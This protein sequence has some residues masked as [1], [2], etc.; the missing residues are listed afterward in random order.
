MKNPII[1]ALF[2]TWFTG[3]LFCLA[4]L[5][6]TFYGTLWLYRFMLA[7][8]KLLLI[9]ALIAVA[10][11]AAAGYVFGPFHVRGRQVEFT[12]EKGATLRAIARTLRQ[13]RVVPSSKAL[14]LWVKLAGIEKKIQA[15]RLSFFAGEG[16]A[17]A[18]Q[19]LLHAEP[20]EVSVT[21]P[22]GLTIAQTAGIIAHVLKADSAAFVNLCLDSGFAKECG[23]S[24]RSLEGY[25]FPDSYRFPPDA[26]PQDIVKKLAGH[27]NEMYASIVQTGTAT[28]LSRRETVVLA[29]I[30]EKEAAIA[31]ERPLISGVF[32]NRLKKRI[33]LG[34]DPTTRYVLGKFSGPLLASDLALQSPYNTR[35]HT[36]L[37]PG[38]ICSPG[39]ASLTAALCPQ[40]TT[41]LYFVARWDGSGSHDFSMTYQEHSRKTDVIRRS[42][43]HR[44]AQALREKAGG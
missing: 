16:V 20:V 39:L 21:V 2:R 34:A 36:G 18:A 32:H 35:L 38:P 13:E 26:G 6:Y 17:A 7:F 40:Q 4:V 33:P 3:A 15:G 41:M 5:G 12:I 37:P 19:G 11:A 8:K 14:I 42:N 27:F 29:S 9:I 1:R 31:S 25:L 22:E 10:A 43:E 24:A 28:G 23:I 44:K 30:I